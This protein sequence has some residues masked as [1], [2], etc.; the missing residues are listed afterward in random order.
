M[1]RRGNNEGSIRHRSDGRWEA[2]IS[3]GDGQRRSLFG[4]TRAEVAK[5]LSEALYEINRELPQDT[6]NQTVRKYLTGWV[7]TVRP[8]LANQPISTAAMCGS[9]YSLR[10]ARSCLSS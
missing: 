2:R 1:T 9:I 5:R 8:T 6:T 10:S 7:E 3:V 4:K